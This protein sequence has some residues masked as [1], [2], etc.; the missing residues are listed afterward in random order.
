[1][2][3]TLAFLVLLAAVAVLAAGAIGSP[4][5]SALAAACPGQAGRSDPAAV[6]ERAMLCL[7]ERARAGHGL[8]PIGATASLNRAADRKSADVLRCDS[9]SHEA[10]G[11]DF[12][13]WM[14]RTGSLGGCWSAAENL[15]WGVGR[16][17]SVDSI[18][19]SWMGSAEHRRNILGPYDEVGI[20]LRVGGLE[21]RAGAHV[22]TQEFVGPC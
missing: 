4:P 13:Y 5:P 19:R 8:A 17:G 2:T 6:Q 10:C 7:V 21:G 1:M 9:F 18:F 16:R 11:R 20:G 14:R 3:R 12:T 15:A 22:W